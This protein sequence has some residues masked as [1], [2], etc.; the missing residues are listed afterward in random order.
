ML[1]PIILIVTIVLFPF[2]LIMWNKARSKGKVVGI[3][4]R[5]DLWV[6][7]ALCEMV[8]DYIIFNGRGYEVYPKLARLMAFPS[9]W[10]K[11][12]QETLPSFL[13]RE[14]DAIPLDWINLGNRMASSTETGTNLDANIYRIM[15]K[16]GSKIAEAGSGGGF[17]FNLKKS[18]P[19][20]LIAIGILGFLA[21]QYFKGSGS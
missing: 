8:D 3:I 2:C 19:F 20:I 1:G 7:M 17:S 16:E 12:L 11:A 13:L 5:G 21:L 4:A 10:P 18:L 6:Q 9:G 15:I 14:D